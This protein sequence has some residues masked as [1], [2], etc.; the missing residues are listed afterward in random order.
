MLSSLS[1]KLKSNSCCECSYVEV[2]QY[3]EAVDIV[4][5]FLKAFEDMASHGYLLGPFEAPTEADIEGE[6][7]PCPEFLSNCCVVM[8]RIIVK[9]KYPRE[10]LLI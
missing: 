3:T 7:E 4:L 9:V 6:I 1:S 10:Y 2:L 5:H 8:V